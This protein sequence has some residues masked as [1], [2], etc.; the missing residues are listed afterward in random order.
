MRA[1]DLPAPEIGQRII[2]IERER[3]VV[4]GEREVVLAHLAVHLAAVG[5][6]LRVIRID[7]DRAVEIGKRFLIAAGAAE[8]AAAH[9][10]GLRVVRIAL[11]DFGK[12]RNVGRRCR[13]RFGVLGRYAAAAAAEVECCAA[14]CERGCA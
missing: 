5:I 10:I 2:L 1:I 7:P 9:V 6:S 11:H 3:L 4:V 12:R 8:H 13:L 14:R